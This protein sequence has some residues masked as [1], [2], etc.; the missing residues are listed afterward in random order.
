M[1]C[2]QGAAKYR[3]EPYQALSARGGPFD[4]E[5]QHGRVVH[6]VQNIGSGCKIVHL[7][8]RSKVADVE[9]GAEDPGRHA[10]VGEQFIVG[11]EVIAGG[12]LGSQLCEA[13]LVREEVA[14]A[15]QHTEGFLHAEYPDKGPLAM[16]L[17]DLVT[18][19]DT[20][21][22]NNVLAGVVAFLRASP[23]EEAAME[24]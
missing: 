5:H 20:L 3:P 4:A 21:R 12:D 11:S 24:G 1:T 13:V 23:E 15:E 17:S 22:S 9:D 8:R 14:H 7:L 10:E 19:R 2:V 18:A 16:E 6:A